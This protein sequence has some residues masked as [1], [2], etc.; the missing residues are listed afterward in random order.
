[1]KYFLLLLSLCLAGNNFAYTAFDGDVDSPQKAK[2]PYVVT[3]SSKTINTYDAKWEVFEYRIGTMQCPGTQTECE[4]LAFA[5]NEA[6]ERRTHPNGG[7]T[8]TEGGMHVAPSKGVVNP[9]SY[10]DAC[11]Q[12]DCGKDSQ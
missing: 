5:L 8:T 6:H 2:Y 10:K 12:D 4:D 11:G 3:V 7:S 9:F 1:M